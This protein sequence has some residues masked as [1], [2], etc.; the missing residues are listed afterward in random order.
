[1]NPQLVLTRMTG[2]DLNYDSNSHR[3]SECVHNHV[4]FRCTDMKSHGVRFNGLCVRKSLIAVSTIK[5]GPLLVV[6]VY[7]PLRMVPDCFM[8]N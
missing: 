2:L 6:Y 5:A 4:G 3:F 7:R 1:M 8:T